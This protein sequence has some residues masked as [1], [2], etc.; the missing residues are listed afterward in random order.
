MSRLFWL[1]NMPVN[2]K[3]KSRTGDKVISSEINIEKGNSDVQ[4]RFF[5]PLIRFPYSTR[6]TKK[7]EELTKH[8]RRNLIANNCML[9]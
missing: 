6:R 5:S 3:D 1:K 9:K 8:L 2:T 7:M 4:I